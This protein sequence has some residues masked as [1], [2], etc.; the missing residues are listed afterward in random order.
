MTTTRSSTE[1]PVRRSSRARRQN[2]TIYDEAAKLEFERRRSRE[3]EERSDPDNSTSSDEHASSSD[4]SKSD[5]DS[6]SIS[7]APSRKKTRTPSQKKKQPPKRSP[8][9]VV[10]RGN[11]R[12]ASSKST[13]KA[14]S[15]SSSSSRTNKPA[16][17]TKTAFTKAR[18]TQALTMLSKKVLNHHGLRDDQ[19]NDNTNTNTNNDQDS[20]NTNTD[21]DN[22][23]KDDDPPADETPRNSLVAALLASA[24]PIPGIPSTA[25]PKS[26]CYQQQHKQQRLREMPGIGTT[27]EKRAS[28][29]VDLCL[30]QLDGILRHLISVTDPNSNSNNTNSDDN[31]NDYNNNNNNK[32][33]NNKNSKNKKN[34]AVGPHEL[35]V[36]LLNL[37]FRSVGGS[38]R[39]T[40]A[41]NDART[42]LDELE[43]NDW[44]DL[45]SRVVTV[46]KNESDAD[47]A[48]L[49]VAEDDDDGERDG[50]G[51]GE[52]DGLQQ[53]QQQQTWTTRQIGILAYRTLYKE[54]WYRL[55]HVLLAHSPSQG[56]AMVGEEDENDDDSDSDDENDDENDSDNE[57]NSNSNSN[58]DS[59]SDS[60]SDSDSD[61]ES[62]SSSSSSSSTRKRSKAQRRNNKKQK[63][64]KKQKKKHKKKTTRSSQASTI[65]STST[66]TTT[67][68]SLSLS[69]ST[70]GFFSNRFQLET[71]RDLILRVTEL[72]SVGQ[73]DLR[74][75]S[76]TA[77]LQLARACIERTVELEQKI[78]V[79]SRQYRVA[80]RGGRSLEKQQALKHR[81]DNWKR[82][83]AEL[84]EIV[85]GPVIQGVFIHRYRDANAT[86]RRDCLRALSELSLIRPDIF[87]VDTYLKYFGWMASD[88]SPAVRIAALEGLSAPFREAGWHDVDVGVGV[89]VDVDVPA[90]LSASTKQRQ[91]Q[92][93]G[94]A[95]GRAA[96]GG[97]AGTTISAS[98]VPFSI[99]LR[100]MHNVLFK[101]LNRIVDCTDDAD[102]SRVRELAVK[103]LLDML[104]EE[105]LDD[106]DDDVAWDKVNIKALDA[107]SSAR[108][109]RDAL[110]FVMDQLDPFDTD[111]TVGLTDRKQ[112]EQLVAIARW[113]ANK[114]C[115]GHIPMDKLNIEL[116]DCI[117]HS[118][119]AMPEHR[120]LVLNWPMMLKAIRSETPQEGA[121][122]EREDTATRRILLRMLATSAGIEREAA[123]AAAFGA[124]SKF[125]PKFNPKS[126]SRAF[127]SRKRKSSSSGTENG[128]EQLSVALLKNLP[129]LLDLFRSDVVSLRDVTKLPLS[130]AS[131][132]LGLPSRKT[133]FQ[134]LVKTLCQL[135]LDSTDEQVLR[136]IART[137]SRW[138]EGDHTR[139]S[140][141]K[142]NLKRLSGA[143][144]DRLME[145]FRESDPHDD[146]D[147]DQDQDRKRKKKKQKSRRRSN[148][149]LSSSQTDGG[150]T[151]GLGSSMF[152]TSPEADLEHSISLLMLRWYILLMQCQ[153]KHLF[154]KSSEDEDEAEGLFFT[155]SEATGKRLSDRMPTVDRDR[156]TEDDATAV[157]T[158]A[159]WDDD[160]PDVHEAAAETIRRSLKVML[161]ILSYELHD[162][163]VDRKEFEA[164]EADEDDTEVDEYKFPVL[165][166]RDNLVKLLGLC[167]DQH[168]P[169]VE[170]VEYTSEQHRFASSVQAGAGEVASDLRTL[171]PWDWSNAADPVRKAMALTGGED[172]TLLLSGFARW[173]QS[174]EEDDSDEA[175]DANA[176]PDSL[177]REALLPLARVTNMN[178]EGF[179]RK[180]AAMIMQHIS[181]SGALASQTI[182]ALSRSLKKTNP[183]RMLE[184]QMACLRLA[185]ENWLDTEP[186]V[187]EET[188][189]SEEEMQAFE[190]AEKRHF[191]SFISMEQ[192]A[193][194]LSSTLGVAGRISNE[195]LKKSIF[196]FMREGIRY[197]FDG[198]ENNLQDDDLVVGSRLAFLSI[199]SKYS[200][201]IKKQKG[202][203]EQLSDYLIAKESELRHHPEFE[204]VHEDD[205]NTLADFKKTLGIKR[206]A[207]ISYDSDDGAP[208]ADDRSYSMATANTLTSGGSSRARP[209]SAASRSSRRSGISVQSELSPLYEEDDDTK[210]GEDDDELSST[211]QKRRRFRS[212][213]SRGEGSAA[214]SVSK[215]A[216][217]RGT[218]LEDDEQESFGGEESDRDDRVDE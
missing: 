70:Q 16:I 31:D 152:S 75:A 69:A 95:A 8:A 68:T 35:Q 29:I 36:R 160:D 17:A 20:D 140:E 27:R 107:L 39:T 100:A 113:C 150:S 101:F 64:H 102:S 111:G 15:S 47:Q 214:S 84:E 51:D 147:E 6:D 81:L 72:V 181:G 191:E 10:K 203:L 99:D 5:S 126:K 13:L 154:E 112:S 175:K 76:T 43:D 94:R 85:E 210:I 88:K 153:T 156:E 190:E 83:K 82:H 103:I 215:S 185:F 34:N 53:Q 179:F 67:S 92:R 46:M 97:G 24:K 63:K 117:V 33:T 205:L 204:E 201:W 199:L 60:D 78:K 2:K 139:V 213:S 23:E 89:G 109:R 168:L 40:L 59:G 42:D 125:N 128:P 129:Y 98:T 121:D 188:S 202:H 12:P 118:I 218:I 80:S 3:E 73:P 44:D 141:V 26:Y 120:N 189:P 158:P 186:D 119:R 61:M 136:N 174:R 165:K 71:V 157:T 124:N 50:D 187:P 195:S 9:V 96:G 155:I 178:F 132:V 127:A 79:A 164:S 106:W 182:L 198:I 162:T 87:L 90:S 122:T 169:R 208:T 177:V 14:S 130:I 173:F 193:S 22:N 49:V 148:R 86:I 18:I 196:G 170:G 77:V 143:M 1:S 114:L 167:F 123:A 144:Q 41:E 74:A 133:D 211:P 21:N 48:L 52:H 38:T 197:A 183:V 19:D 138:V 134:N 163:L 180:E 172:F 192:V 54:F 55:G 209:S 62:S 146:D 142:I 145:L 207:E 149:R 104:R 135:Y 184:S 57:S 93:G 58:D 216:Q 116:V 161:L 66:S 65:T 108:V 110:Y 28:I 30:P 217:S 131:S 171:F 37:M 56:A 105:F 115:D 32:N 200:M 25:R 91:Q 151:V 137:L 7:K 159:I 206:V 45:V 194:K 166:L 212:P 176:N 4:E 11:K